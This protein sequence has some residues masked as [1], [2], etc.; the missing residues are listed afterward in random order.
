MATHPQAPS[1]RGGDLVADALARHLALELREGE[2]HVER[3][4]AHRRGGVELLGHRDEGDAV[5]VEGLD[6]PGEV[7]ERAGQPVDLVD[8]QE[9]D[10]AAL[11]IGQKALQRRSRHG[12]AGETTIV[13]WALDELPTLVS[14]AGGVGFTGLPLGVQ[15]I[16]SLVQAL[17]GRLAGVDRAP[18]TR[19]RWSNHGSCRC[20]GA[21][22]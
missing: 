16:E 14:L 2:Q 22:S 15:G 8:E 21:G 19:W 3:E 12:A 7:G 20:G 1:T 11:D 9:V 6:D 13:V 4:P 18:Q 10:P 5:R 17:L